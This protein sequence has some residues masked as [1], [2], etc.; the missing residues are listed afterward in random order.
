VREPRETAAGDPV[1]R[2]AFPTVTPG[3]N[4]AN[5]RSGPASSVHSLRITSHNLDARRRIEMLVSFAIAIP[6]GWLQAK[7]RSRFHFS[8][9]CDYTP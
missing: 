1:A 3:S 7:E 2:R 4:G 9:Q 5:H 8:V 6:P